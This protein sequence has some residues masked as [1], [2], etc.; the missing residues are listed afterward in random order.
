MAKL[1][2]ILMPVAILLGILLPQAHVLSPALP[3][4]IGLMMFLSF[5]GK[6]PP[7]Q[8]GYTFKIEVKAF[9]ASLVM[10]A[11]L[12][13]V[14]EFF[15][16][17]REVLLGGAIICLC[18]PANA[19]PAMAKV[20]GGNPVLALKIFL[21]GNIIACFSIP[22]IYGYLTGADASFAEV[23]MKIFNS[24]QPII[25]I[26]LAIALGL[27]AFYPELADKAVRFQKYTLLVWTISVFLILAKASYD[28]REMGFAELWN[29]GKLSMLAL[30]AL[31]LCIVQ[32]TVGW[33]SDKKHPIESSQSM[34][35]KNTTL[36]I[37][38]SSLYAGPVAAIAPTCYVIWQNLVLSWMCGRKKKK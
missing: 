7:Q 4:M 9:L 6:V 13:G 21:S 2:S 14:V 12:W 5:V 22:L 11:V 16:L 25:S 33:F 26:P 37:W 1:R 8:H 23:A 35:Q 27:R 17:P 24:I 3:F 10:L 15:Q 36:V 31:I 30:V 34:G 28:I 29:S 18:P 20:L 32:F 38:I 19:A